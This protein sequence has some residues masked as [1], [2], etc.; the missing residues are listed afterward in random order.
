MNDGMQVV[1]GVDVEDVAQRNLRESP[2]DLANR[3]VNFLLSRVSL[4]GTQIQ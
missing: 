3:R 1:G 2:R 4:N